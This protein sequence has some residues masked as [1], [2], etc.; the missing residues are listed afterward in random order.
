MAKSETAAARD[1]IVGLEPGTWFWS[2]EIP[3]RSEIT[4]PVLSRLYANKANGIWKLGRGLYWRGCPEG[5]E[6]F[7]MW[8]DFEVGAMM[9]AGPGAGLAGWSALHTLGWT[10][11]RPAKSFICV[12]GRAPSPPDV[13]VVYA[14]SK[15]ACRAE[16]NWTE[17]TVLEAVALHWMSE[18]PWH[19]C[20]DSIRDRSYANRLRWDSTIRPEKLQWAAEAEQDATVE[21]LYMVDD[22]SLAMATLAEAV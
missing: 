22:L 3:G 19:E 5:H 20:L 16:L 10:L 9:L 2:K 8:P 7:G 6:Y 4:G 15:N 11:Q 14:P 21:T 13:S 18:E 12:L 1:W 17:V